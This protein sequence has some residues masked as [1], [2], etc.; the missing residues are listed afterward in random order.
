MDQEMVE[1]S[2]AGFC[3]WLTSCYECLHCATRGSY[4]MFT[5]VWLVFYGRVPTH[6]WKYLNLFLLNSRPWKYLKRGQVL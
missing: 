3:S 6:P 2:P 5:N 4:S 1:E